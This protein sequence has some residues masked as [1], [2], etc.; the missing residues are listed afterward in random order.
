MN[1]NAEM[2]DHS[3]IQLIRC[4]FDVVIPHFLTYFAIGIF[5]PVLPSQST[6]TFPDY[7]ACQFVFLH[8]YHEASYWYSVQLAPSDQLGPDS[9]DSLGKFRQ[10]GLRIAGCYAL[11]IIFFTVKLGQFVSSRVFLDTDI[12]SIS[13]ENFIF[14]SKNLAKNI[15]FIGGIS[16]LKAKQ[17]VWPS[18][19]RSAREDCLALEKLT[20][21][22]MLSQPMRECKKSVEGPLWPITKVQHWYWASFCNLSSS[23]GW[24][25]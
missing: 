7:V 2:I 5:Q 3:Q 18:T 12:T 9:C 11:N 4:F 15:S 23:Q 25:G 24:G 21:F 6:K 22:E 10:G 20:L 13:L 14:F 16:S 17:A 1:N 8:R 19:Q